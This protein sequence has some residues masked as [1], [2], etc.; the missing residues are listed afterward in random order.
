[1][2]DLKRIDINVF[3]NFLEYE[4]I[5][6]SVNGEPAEYTPDEILGV[7]GKLAE[8]SKVLTDNLIANRMK[9]INK[10]G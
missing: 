4:T 7:L 8:L 10:E 1:M 5:Q 3:G 9:Q 2:K 6:I